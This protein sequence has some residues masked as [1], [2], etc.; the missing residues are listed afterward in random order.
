MAL[1][2]LVVH[3][4]K[5]VVVKKMKIAATVIISL[6]NISPKMVLY[7]Y[8]INTE[9]NYYGKYSYNNYTYNIDS[10]SYKKYD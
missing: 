4:V 8:I 3:H 7:K 10:F 9:R 2:V 6:F 5:V 1:S